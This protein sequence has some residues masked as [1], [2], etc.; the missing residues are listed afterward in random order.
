[1]KKVL[2]T[3][4]FNLLLLSNIFSQ[5]TQSNTLI[6]DADIGSPNANITAVSWITGQ[7][8]GVAFGGVTEENWSKPLGGSM[9]ATFKLVVDGEIN[10]YEIL[11]I[12]EENKTLVMRLKHFNN[13]LTGWEE[14]DEVITF[15]L[16]KIT[17]NKVFFNGLTFEKISAKE[18]NIYVV[19]ESDE[20]QIKET[21]FNFRRVQ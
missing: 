10:F 6:Y 18:M 11:T 17:P 8:R 21:K 13:D 2:L 19:V 4:F 20:N 14:K 16:V 12:T 3:V 7:W 15:N 9:M 5:E 1:M